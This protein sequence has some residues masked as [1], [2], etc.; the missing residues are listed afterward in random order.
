MP[1]QKKIK[2]PKEEI[3]ESVD[4]SAVSEK[5]DELDKAID[6][7]LL[8][9]KADGYDTLEEKDD[10]LNLDDSPIQTHGQE[11]TYE[12]KIPKDRIAVLIGKSGETKKKIESETHIKLNINS[13]DC[14]VS[15]SGED[16][17]GL[18]TAREV[19]RAISRGFNP[20]YALQLLKS[21]YSFEVF[22]I[23]DYV[24]KN[25]NA[26]LRL[27]GRIIGKEGKARRII[28]ELT[29]ANLCVYGKTIG[30]IG[31]IENVSIARRAV[32]S[33]LSGAPHANVYKWLEHRRKELKMKNMLEREI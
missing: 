9:H 20:E 28:E 31:E 29:E 15:I 3:S 25:K 26:I 8:L 12:I 18:Y 27:K 32:Q 10:D 19:V 24:G 17:L 13:K 1:R 11:F 4:E 21:D 22:N 23:I 7:S 14:D 33:L 16:A 2:T 30:I 6:D 5:T